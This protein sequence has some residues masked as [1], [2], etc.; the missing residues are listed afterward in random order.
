MSAISFFTDDIDF[1]LENQNA[2]SEWLWDIVRNEGGKI[3][4][5]TY[6]F[7][8]DERLLEINRQFLNHDYYTD[9]ITFQE[10]EGLVSGEIYISVDRVRENA[11]ELGFS[12]D[13]ELHRVLS[14]GLLHMLGYNDTSDEQ[15]QTMRSRED[16]YL[17]LRRF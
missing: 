17:T 5:V 12:F 3:T 16:F 2:V 4:S 10:E 7:V 9:I 15:K 8:S 13:N 11:A 1:K 14:H 6:V